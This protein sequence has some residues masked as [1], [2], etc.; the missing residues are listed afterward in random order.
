MVD[1]KSVQKTYLTLTALN[2]LAASFIWGVNT[3]FL[4][5]AGLTN[6]Q[7]FAANAFFTLGQVIFEIPTGIVADTYGRRLSYLLGSATLILTTFVYLL[8]WKMQGAP[9]FAWA[10]ASIF[11]GLGFTFFSGATEAWLVDALDFTK[12]KGQIEDVF[13][14]GQIANGI[15]MLIGSTLGGAVAQATD[16]GVPYLLRCAVLFISFAAAW[17]LMKDLGFTPRKPDSLISEMKIILKSSVKNGLRNA[18][19]RWMMFVG[20][21][22][23][24]VAFYGFY[25]S[26]PL[27][28]EL[29]GDKKAYG[30]AGLIASIVAGAQILG[31][32]AVPLIRKFF[33]RRSSVIM[34]II[35]ASVALLTLAGLSRDFVPVLILLALWGLLGAAYL[36]IQR[37]YLN[38]LIASKERATLLS[39]DGMITSIGGSIMQ[40]GLGKAADVWGYSA[41]FFIAGVLQIF[42]LPF[43]FLVRKENSPADHFGKSKV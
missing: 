11:L 35:V 40:P 21:F 13:G 27:L 17:F 42:A 10:L 18:P 23:G 9:F 19:V 25:A 39:F 12:F 31:G 15:S 1:S 36:P 29:Y 14:R 2:T 6:A 33:Q 22:L 38:K 37:A 8:L 5:D 28:L 3:L 26:Q 16:L 41:S 4:L 7:A 30:I 34:F 20:P 32:L 43:I 24:G